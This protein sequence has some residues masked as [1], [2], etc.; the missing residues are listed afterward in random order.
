MRSRGR[1]L[2][3]AVVALSALVLAVVAAG[4][5]QAPPRPVKVKGAPE[6]E[7]A[8]AY[9]RSR[10]LLLRRGLTERTSTITRVRLDGS[11]D[12]SFGDDGT[13][14]I[15]AE[16]V[17][18]TRDGKILVVATGSPKGSKH[19]EARVTRLRSD[20]KLDR[21]FGHNGEAFAD[22]G[23][24]GSGQTIAV[25]SDGDI[26]VAGIRIDA[27]DPTTGI[28]SADLAVARLKANGAID[29]SFGT[30]GVIFVPVG[31]EIEAIDIAPTPSGGVIVEEGNELSAYLE[32][33][34]RDGSPD[35]RFGHQGFVAVA[36]GRGK[37]AAHQ[38]LR[39]LPGFAE[40]PSGKLLITGYASRRMKPH[41]LAVVRLG[42]DG[43]IDHFYGRHGWATVPGDLETTPAALALLPGGKLAVGTTFREEG[44]PATVDFGAV[45]FTPGGHLEHRFADHGTCRAGL[46]SV[47]GTSV[48][49]VGG[50]P[51]ALGGEGKEQWLLNCPGAR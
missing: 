45:V 24:E 19:A 41:Q 34:N 36:A 43:R 25:G 29:T 44:R 7:K 32:K 28:I 16:D 5:A 6:G 46:A 15:D 33:F 48:A 18:V 17:A 31:D 3:F 10:L 4:A 26:L 40:L 20:G 51:V 22:F 1:R 37:G 12:R 8:I 35:N 50:H 49:T 11:L 42:L 39:P 21:S 14:H 23:S 47:D 30:K 13:V 38:S 2:T 9:G 27:T